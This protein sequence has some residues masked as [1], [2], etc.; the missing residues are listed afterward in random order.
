MSFQLK[1]QLT[2]VIRQRQQRYV[3]EENMKCFD[4]LCKALPF[5]DDEGSE[6]GS[7]LSL[8]SD[9]GSG[10]HEKIKNHVKPVAKKDGGVAN[11]NGTSGKGLS[12]NNKTQTVKSNGNKTTSPVSG[13]S[14]R[15]SSPSSKSL[16][17]KMSS[18]STSTLL[19]WKQDVTPISNET[20]ESNHV[21]SVNGDI[22]KSSTSTKLPPIIHKKQ[23]LV[24]AVPR[25]DLQQQIEAREKV[26]YNMLASYNYV[27]V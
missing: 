12:L 20:I 23:A 27:L 22:T 5:E 9:E 7:K 6:D 2:H 24:K 10:Q 13:A 3:S 26:C 15:D 17:L 11:S 14:K 25:V 8:L 18:N 21:A 16:D 1:H 4:I 19:S